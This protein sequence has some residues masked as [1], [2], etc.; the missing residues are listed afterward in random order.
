MTP[1]QAQNLLVILGR[2]QHFKGVV[3]TPSEAMLF[4]ASVRGLEAIASPPDDENEDA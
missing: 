2:V 1:E 4:A 3:E